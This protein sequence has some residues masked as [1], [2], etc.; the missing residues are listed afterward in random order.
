MKNPKQTYVT[1]HVGRGGRFNNQGHKSFVDV[2]D[3]QELLNLECNR[4]LI[5]AI[6]D[7][8]G[9]VI[10]MADGQGNC[11]V[12]EY[13]I[14]SLKGVLDY[15]GDYDRYITDEINDCDTDE[16]F[17]CFKNYDRFVFENDRINLV[18]ALN[19]D[20]NFIGEVDDESL[21]SWYQDN[22]DLSNEM[23]NI[24]NYLIQWGYIDENGNVIE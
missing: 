17:M 12:D 7:E 13:D 1:F 16:L 11:V 3:F 20:S 15:D 19:N 22:K 2:M 23:P 10:G 21:V 4:N 6:E 24:K 14:D 18:K 5:Y 9:N 8:N